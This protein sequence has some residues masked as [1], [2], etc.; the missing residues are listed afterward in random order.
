[1]LEVLL[2]IPFILFVFLV[3]ATRHSWRLLFILLLVGPF[4]A[5]AL[6]IV[7]EVLFINIGGLP[8]SLLDWVSFILTLYLLILPMAIIYPRSAYVALMALLAWTVFERSSW[9]RTKDRAG[10]IL[11]ATGVG[12]V[13]G[14]S[15]AL[16]LFL[17]YQNSAFVDFVSAGDITSR[18]LPPLA[19]PM[20]IVTGTVDGA[21]IAIFGIKVFHPKAHD[22]VVE[23]VTA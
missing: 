1:M 19:I 3:R 7:G 17:A 9:S 23:G 6:L 18:A 4:I 8:P 22:G 20:A 5:T 2:V 21:L 15:F 13:T 14:A 11:I 16:L 12:T 10:R